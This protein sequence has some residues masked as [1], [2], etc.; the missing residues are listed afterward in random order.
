[1]PTLQ[2]GDG[3]NWSFLD[4]KWK[5]GPEGQLIPPDEGGKAYLA[6]AHKDE[7]SDFSAR[8]RFKFRYPHAGARFLFRVQDSMRYYAL[9]IPW[10]GQQNRNRHFWTGIVRADGSPL[11][12]S[13]GLLGDRLGRIRG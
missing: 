12:L 5:D 7:Y 1:M 11:V 6:V 9:D 13:R 8:F 3:S 2:I 10:C 4:G